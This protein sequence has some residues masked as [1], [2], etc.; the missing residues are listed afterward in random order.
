MFVTHAGLNSVYETLYRGVPVVAIPHKGDQ[1]DHASQLEERGLGLA[2]D[3]K[4]L[5]VDKL[6]NAILRVIKEPG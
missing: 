5:T 4:I 2:I 6:Y 1:F 3:F